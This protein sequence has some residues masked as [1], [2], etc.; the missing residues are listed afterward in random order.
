MRRPW[1]TG[2]CQPRGRLS[3]ERGMSILPPHARGAVASRGAAGGEGDL[4]F[5]LSPVGR[6]RLELE[7]ELELG[8][9]VRLVSEVPVLA[10]QRRG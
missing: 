6:P 8:C 4:R 2:R 9:V 3:E 7:P 10:A 5:S 1:P